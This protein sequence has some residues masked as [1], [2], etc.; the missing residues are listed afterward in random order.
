[1]SA[2]KRVTD[3]L[4]EVAGRA[5][6]GDLTYKDVLEEIENRHYAAIRALFPAKIQSDVIT[7]LLI[8]PVNAKDKSFFL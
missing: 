1:V 7:I 4:F 3:Q 8:N 5:S 2:F 6:K